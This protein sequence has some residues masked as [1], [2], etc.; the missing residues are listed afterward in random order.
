M[1]PEACLM[2]RR[3]VRP[4]KASL[5]NMAAALTALRT[6]SAHDNVSEVLRS[7]RVNKL[8]LLLIHQRKKKLN[9]NNYIP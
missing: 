4:G 2:R 9:I 8:F 5:G 7:P 1:K 3:A 6:H